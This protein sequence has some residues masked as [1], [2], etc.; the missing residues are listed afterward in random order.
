[1]TTSIK[2]MV[3]KYCDDLQTI[4]I[5]EQDETFCNK[6][7]ELEKKNLEK[8]N[9][10]EVWFRFC[11]ALLKCLL[12]HGKT[13]FAHESF[14]FLMQGHTKEKVILC[15]ERNEQKELGLRDTIEAF[16]TKHHIPLDQHLQFSMDIEEEEESE[17]EESDSEEDSDSEEEEEENDDHGRV[18]YMFVKKFIPHSVDLSNVCLQLSE[19]NK[20]Y[21]EELKNWFFCI[22]RSHPHVF[23]ENVWKECIGHFIETMDVD[24]IRAMLEVNRKQTFVLPHQLIK[25]VFGMV[26]D[27][28]TLEEKKEHLLQLGSILYQFVVHSPVPNKEN[29]SVGRPKPT[30]NW[31]PDAPHEVDTRCYAPLGHRNR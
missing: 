30:G 7:R 4:T 22:F 15:L 3:K 18:E 23:G 11:H 10:G 9:G 21:K 8:K 25:F 1:M 14:S 26:A 13:Y 6:L 24:G 5:S 29:R 19:Y 20:Q 16:A 12:D 2:N 17:E 28:E 31:N 27:V